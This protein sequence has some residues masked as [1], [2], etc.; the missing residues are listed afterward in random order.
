MAPFFSPDGQWIG[1]VDSETRTILQ[2]VS[3]F[4]G[5]PVRLAE[6]PSPIRGASW[7]ADDQIIFG[8]Q[9][10]F[11]LYRVSGGGGDLEVLSPPDGEVGE[12]R[13]HTW[14]FII[15]DRGAIVFVLGTG[16][17]LATGQLAVLDLANGDV[18]P[19]SLAGVSPRYI[20]TGHLVYVTGEGGDSCSPFRRYLPHSHR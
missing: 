16:A 8:R 11:P 17:P 9:G 1:F 19:L 5:A 18:T 14:P 13:N 3:V 4:G 12:T 7:G 2:K 15:P 6:L 20:S 10:L